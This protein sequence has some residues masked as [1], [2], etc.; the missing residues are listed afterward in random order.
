MVPSWT[1]TLIPQKSGITHPRLTVQ[2]RSLYY[3]LGEQHGTA[4]SPSN[5][6]RWPGSHV[7]YGY[8]GLGR[9]FGI[10]SF[11]IKAGAAELNE[12]LLA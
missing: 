12:K 10:L 5:E 11:E 2:S 9:T 1:D 7:I 6:S 3:L 8:D 4:P